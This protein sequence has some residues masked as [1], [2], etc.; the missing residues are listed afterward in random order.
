MF[1]EHQISILEW[2]L[3]DHVTLKTGVMM[4]KI[5]L[6]ITGINYILKC[7]K[8]EFCWIV[9]FQ[10]EFK[11]FLLYQINAAYTIDRQTDR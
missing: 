6:C 10:L 3:K 7:I 5:Q 11:L 8:V 9:I 2:F 4:L 1:L